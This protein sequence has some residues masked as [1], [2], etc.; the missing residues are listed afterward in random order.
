MHSDTLSKQIAETVLKKQRPKDINRAAFL[1]L[2][3]DIILGIKDGWRVKQIWETLHDQG[4]IS[5]S[6]QTFTV[7]ANKLIFHKDQ[8]KKPSTIDIPSQTNTL[9]PEDQKITTP[10]SDSQSLI[11]IGLPPWLY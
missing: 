5:F 11:S 8:E 1:A 6:Y 3:D 2:R 10:S 7:Y 9:L 4:K